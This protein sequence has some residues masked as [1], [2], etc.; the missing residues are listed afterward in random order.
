MV[1]TL[2]QS[3]EENNILFKI[4]FDVIL[5]LF[6]HFFFGMTY[7][8]LIKTQLKD[9]LSY[10]TNQTKAEIRVSELSPYCQVLL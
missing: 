2:K 1:I 6:R 8:A 3:A 10:N 5:A 9:T 7:E 4:A